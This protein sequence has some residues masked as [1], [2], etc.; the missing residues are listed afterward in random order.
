MCRLIWSLV[1]VY[2]PEISASSRHEHRLIW[3]TPFPRYRQNHE[4]RLESVGPLSRLIIGNPIEVFQPL[5]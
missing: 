3:S 5:S 1:K 4:I 2:W